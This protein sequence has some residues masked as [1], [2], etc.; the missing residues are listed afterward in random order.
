MPRVRS[1][2]PSPVLCLV[3]CVALLLGACRGDPGQGEAAEPPPEPPLRIGAGPDAES[4]LLAHVQAALLAREGI[5]AEVVPFPSGR[6]VQQALEAGRIELRPA[7][8]G[9]AWLESLGRADPPGDPATS[10]AAVREHDEPRGL[11]WL[12]PAR[13][14][15]PDEPP[16]NATFAFVVLGPP[17]AH[18]DLRTM[19]QLAT[20][21]SE[22]PEAAVCVDREF[23]DRT[24]GL[25][26]VLAAY[27]IRSDRP[28]LAAEPAA[29][30]AAVAGGDCLAGLTTATDGAA[31][32]AGLRPLV[33]DLRVFPAF[34]PLPLV[35][36]EVLSREPQLRFALAPLSAQ[37][38]T[39][40]LGDLNARVVAGEPL[41]EVA[42]DAAT[43][44]A[45]RAGREPPPADS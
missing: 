38:T 24:D 30:V 14:D 8:S 13:F 31:W 15:G 1:A 3:L 4:R 32:L 45:R 19:S 2:S 28:F 12:P 10:V 7:Y 36:R 9:E 18:A 26:A 23:A 22:L 6:E 40:L 35:R 21:L 41:P 39:A 16:A 44:L 43:E 5:P 42:A 25:P 17:G 29:A 33:D 34:V 37:L 11:V 20:R 27:S